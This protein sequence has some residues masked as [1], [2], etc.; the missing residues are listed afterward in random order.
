M[1]AL[2]KSFY[3]SRNLNSHPN[4]FTQECAEVLS[5]LEAAAVREESRRLSEGRHSNGGGRGGD[6]LSLRLPPPV[7][8]PKLVDF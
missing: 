3:I 8:E 7:P 1:L 5:R 6:L 2:K 4:G